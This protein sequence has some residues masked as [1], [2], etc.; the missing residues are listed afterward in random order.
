MHTPSKQGLKPHTILSLRTT[1]ILD[2]AVPPLK[3]LPSG[4]RWNTL[5]AWKVQQEVIATLKAYNHRLI[6]F[7]LRVPTPIISLVIMGAGRVLPICEC[8]VG[9]KVSLPN[10]WT[11]SPMLKIPCLKLGQREALQSITLRFPP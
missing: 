1:D 2:R 11:S 6:C 8:C 5:Q 9:Y 4:Q 7:A 3:Q 10:I